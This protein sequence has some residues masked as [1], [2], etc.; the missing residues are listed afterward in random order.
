MSDPSD[1]DRSYLARVPRKISFGTGYDWAMWF[2]TFMVFFAFGAWATPDSNEAHYLTKAKHFW[3][4]NWLAND[5]FLNSKDAH[6]GFYYL[7]GWLTAIVDL[8][9]AAWLGRIVTWAI[10]AWAWQRLGSRCLQRQEL[11]PLT[12]ALWVLLNEH[13]HMAGEWVVGGFE[14]KG[15]AMA[16]IVFAL[17]EMVIGNWR[18]VF[19]LLGCAA[20]MH[21]L[22]GGWA[23]LAAG[24]VWLIHGRKQ[25]PLEQI[26][27]PMTL[28]VAIAL[29][30]V[31]WG[32]NLNRG[33]EPAII[34]LAEK[35]YFERLPHHLNPLSDKFYGLRFFGLSIVT[36]MLLAA[37]TGFPWNVIQT[38]TLRSASLPNDA[39]P[40]DPLLVG[41]QNLALFVVATL[42]ITIT[43]FA[44][45]NIY[46][47]DKATLYR[48]MR[49]YWF[50]ASD[51][52][53]PL[54]CALA[55]GHCTERLESFSKRIFQL[56]FIGLTLVT[57]YGLSLHVAH[58][59][60]TVPFIHQAA[61]YGRNDTGATKEHTDKFYKMCLHIRDHLPESANSR[62][63]IQ[64]NLRT[65]RWH[66]NRADVG[67]HK[68]IPQDARSIASWQL[69]I[70]T[71]FP[72]DPTP[73]ND[74]RRLHLAKH[75]PA[76][77]L[78]LAR[79]FQA[80]YLLVLYKPEDTDVPILPWKPIAT[81]GDKDQGY[82][83]LYQL[84][85]PELLNIDPQQTPPLFQPIR[86]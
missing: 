40:A 85:N 41:W 1:L 10:Q 73:E 5:P 9:V 70:D 64:H 63:L 86:P 52:W 29:P 56:S 79:Q 48:L 30:A 20:F 2:G 16:F 69:M 32:I 58:W 46:F 12:A 82:F 37:L 50:R 59:P 74:K 4:P 54:G 43:G 35:S 62:F 77:L 18:W 44:L 19:P 68:D 84:S 83:A 80:D 72:F 60:F 13:F 31:W 81:I 38:R 66:A 36:V 17:A 6:T 11:V 51:A 78:Q 39:L 28:G 61:S 24:V 65:F 55:I 47:D 7:A 42:G 76:K 49:Y 23:M 33:V 34:E 53:V 22:T 45:H 8:P 21:V 3:Q 27:W 25:T 67:N 26:I 15:F 71:L 75:G 57:G 14:G